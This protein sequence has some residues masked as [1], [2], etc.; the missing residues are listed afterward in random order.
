MTAKDQA[1]TNRTVYFLVR[2]TAD[3][4]GR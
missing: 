3:G 2:A 1:D 4:S